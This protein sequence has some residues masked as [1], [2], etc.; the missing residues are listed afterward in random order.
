[1]TWKNK[2]WDIVEQFYWWPRYLGM[3]SI[4][5]K[6]WIKKDGLICVPEEMVNKTGPLYSRERKVT[7]LKSYLH[8]SEEILNHIFDLTFSIAPD[9]MIND[10]LLNPLGFADSGPFESLG[11][12]VGM[13]YGW[14]EFD[15]V[16]QQDGLFVSEQSIVAVELKLLS[17][18]WPE[19][20]IKYAALLA[21]EEQHKGSRKQLGLLFIVPE[22]AING[23][24]KKCGLKGPSVDRTFLEQT[25]K[26]RLPRFIADMLTTRQDHVAS[27][28]DRME[29][30]LISWEDL[31]EKC[32]PCKQPS[33]R[34]IVATK[35]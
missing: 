20:I 31:Q 24:W 13:R 7:D 8:G 30:G 1:M 23:H 29:L 17:S 15:N 11:R 10:I 26:R 32:L 14:G 3:R 6:H 18:S 25:W 16:T 4:P 21:L 9:S 27:V 35:P 34:R 5:Q 2:Y 22:S 19:Q 12:E 33:I 28:L